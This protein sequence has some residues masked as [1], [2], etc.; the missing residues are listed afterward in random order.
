MLTPSTVVID[1][2]DKPYARY[3]DCV[4]AVLPPTST[5]GIVIPGVSAS[6]AK[7]SRWLG[8]S[9]NI[10]SP[11]FVPTVAFCTS[12]IGE[13]PVTTIVASMSAICIVTFIVMVLATGNIGNKVNRE[14]G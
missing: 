7:R 2:P 5:R 14:H 10:A 11:K 6:R 8:M 3:A 1:W 12:T 4:P 13:L 9:R